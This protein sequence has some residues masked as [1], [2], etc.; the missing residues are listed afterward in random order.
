MV[1]HETREIIETIGTGM[2]ARTIMLDGG[3]TILWL[4]KWDND[5]KDWGILVH[6]TLHAVQFLFNRINLGHSED[7]WE[8]FAYQQQ[9][10]F[11]QIIKVIK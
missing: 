9:Y 8:A 1:N 2:D 10:I 7:S 3:Q 5:S 11:E 6:E 4:K